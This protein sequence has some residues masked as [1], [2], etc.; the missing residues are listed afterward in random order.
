MCLV[1]FTHL[2]MVT[3][4]V[5]QAWMAPIYPLSLAQNVITTGLIAFRIW[6]QLCTSTMNHVFDTSSR[7]TLAR[8]LRI[9]VESAAIY[10]IQILILVVIT[11]MRYNAHHIVQAAIIPS[12]GA[13]HL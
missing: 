5:I 10:T 7:L 12:I 4:Q 9:I 8:I 11:P 1:W 13:K 3:L 2:D 6:A